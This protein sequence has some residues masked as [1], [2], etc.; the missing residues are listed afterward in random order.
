[1]LR[2]WRRSRWRAARPRLCGA[3]L[4]SYSDRRHMPEA[5][6]GEQGGTQRGRVGR[7]AQGPVTVVNAPVGGAAKKRGA[8][9]QGGGGPTLEVIC[10]KEHRSDGDGIQKG[11]GQQ[12]RSRLNEEFAMQGHLSGFNVSVPTTREGGDVGH[13]SYFIAGFTMNQLLPSS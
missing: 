13:Q 4:A 2:S 7:L 9:M 5:K 10:K 1:S 6:I 12:H 11:N 8:A 3:C